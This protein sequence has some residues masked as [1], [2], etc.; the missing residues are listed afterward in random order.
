V[1]GEGEA[2]MRVLLAFPGTEVLKWA[3]W[4]AGWR[5]STDGIGI[6]DTC[7]EITVQLNPDGVPDHFRHYRSS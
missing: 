4:G 1:A 2:V 7:G 3:T 6:C 5:D